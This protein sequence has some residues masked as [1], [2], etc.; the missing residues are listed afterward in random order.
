MRKSYL[1]MLQKRFAI[2][3]VLFIITDEDLDDWLLDLFFDFE[4]LINMLIV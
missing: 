4:W 2:E 1:N 3:G